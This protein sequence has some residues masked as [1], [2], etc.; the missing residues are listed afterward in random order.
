MAGMARATLPHSLINW[1]AFTE[2]YVLIHD[3]IEVVI[4]VLHDYNA[5][6]AKPGELRMDTSVS[7]RE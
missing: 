3:A 1:E 2:D 5:Y 7:H 4:P 6:I